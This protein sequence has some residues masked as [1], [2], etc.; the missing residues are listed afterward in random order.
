MQDTVSNGIIALNCKKE[1]K[2]PNQM[3]FTFSTMIEIRIKLIL[4]V[5]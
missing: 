4:H 5:Q 3:G 1:R 2:K